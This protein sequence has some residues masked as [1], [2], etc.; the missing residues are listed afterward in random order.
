MSTDPRRFRTVI[1]DLDGT[2]VDTFPDVSACI[3]RALTAME[4]TPL[5][6][7]RARAAIGPGKDVFLRT[8]LGDDAEREEERFLKIFRGF[9]ITHCLDN[10]TLFPDMETVLAELASHTLI[11][12]TNKPGAAA[13]RILA[14]LGVLSCFAMVVGPEQVERAKPAPDMIEYA[15]AATGGE[16]DSAVIIGDTELDMQAGRAAGIVTAAALYGYG[17]RARVR[18]A[19]PDFC[20]ASPREILN[21]F[22]HHYHKVSQCV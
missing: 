7:E 20:L 13:R 9:Y 15:L 3:N 10:T 6:P 16:K 21:L 17:D 1:F 11:V 12:A 18:D 14:G 5:P 22:N 2:L 4:R 19:A 8:I